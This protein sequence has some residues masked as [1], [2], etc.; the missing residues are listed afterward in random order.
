MCLL[1][2]YFIYVSVTCLF[3]KERER[4]K[5]GVELG[6]CGEGRRGWRRGPVVKIYYMKSFKIIY[7]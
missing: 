4:K 7:E 1:C 2:F 6:G 5:T 3:S